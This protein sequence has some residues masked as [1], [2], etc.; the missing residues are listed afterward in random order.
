MKIIALIPYWSDYAF[1]ENSLQKRDT[2]SLGGQSLMDHIINTLGNVE[3]INTTIIF[4]SSKQVENDLRPSKKLKFLARSKDLDNQAISIED[5]IEN[6]LNNCDADIVVLVHPRCPFVTAETINNCIQKVIFD[7]FDSCFVVSKE[8]KLAWFNGK[9]LN[10]SI[11]KATP[12]LKELE[13]VILETSSL[14]IFSRKSFNKTRSRVGGN[15]YMYE[16]G[17]FEGL[18]VST[19]EDFEMAELIINSGLD[20]LRK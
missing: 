7:S 11:T 18:E 15:F 5:I 17:N 20:K 10:Y 9:P 2:L 6:F 14:Y 12:N 4:S 8:K 3:K 16:V 19:E 13:P 1:P